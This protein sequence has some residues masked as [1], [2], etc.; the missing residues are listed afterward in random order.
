[1][2]KPLN[3]TNLLLITL[4]LS[5]C[6]GGDSGGGNSNLETGQFIDSPVEGLS[7]S[8][9]TQSG[10][11]NSNGEFKYKSG[12]V[13]KF[14]IGAID[15]GS[16]FGSKYLS[17]IDVTNTFVPSDEAASNIARLLQTLDVDGDPENGIELPST[18]ASLAADL[19]INDTAAVETAIAKTLVSA[20]EAETH[21][22]SSL[23]DLPP[24]SID[25]LYERVTIGSTGNVGCDVITDAQIEVS[26]DSAGEK[27]YQ[28]T[29]NLSGGGIYSFTADDESI[30]NPTVT[31]DPD[32]TY[33]INLKTFEG[34][35]EVR[36][37]S[38]ETSLKI[39]AEIYLTTES[40][41]N[42][43]PIV[44]K[45][46]HVTTVP[47]CTSA[48]KTYSLD[49]G[50]GA[51]DKDGFIVGDL[52]VKFARD[53]NELVSLNK[54]EETCGLTGS[55]G[56]DKSWSP[57]ANSR[58]GC[59][60]L[61]D[62]DD[63]PCTSGFK[64]EVSATDNE[65]LTSTITGGEDAPISID[66]SGN[67]IYQCHENYPAEACEI[68]SPSLNGATSFVAGSCAAIVPKP[69]VTINASDFG[70]A[71]PSIFEGNVIINYDGITDV[72]AC[73]VNF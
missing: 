51:W 16:A 8:T 53:G 26:R 67:G 36:N 52:D 44:S 1:M 62:Q 20:S 56:L 71:D 31:D 7:Y 15:I 27:V 65:G 35:I 5:A 19:D 66:I 55:G 24:L 32:H 59:Y 33:H 37:I 9:D 2:L 47:N 18:I 50:F 46:K 3:T 73:L 43:P 63:I 25:G 34:S 13:V 54:D 21:L 45:G 64:W 40:A 58:V 29:I 41:V 61:G 6:G 10:K 49:F 11:T 39:C 30:R 4:A 14:K 17:P 68:V 48:A 72:V 42:L 60:Y 12:E 38:G 69:F 28:G 57:A 22:E 23:S 70:S